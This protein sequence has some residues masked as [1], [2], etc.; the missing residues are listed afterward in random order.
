VDGGVKLG[1]IG[2]DGRELA[3]DV[4]RAWRRVRPRRRAIDGKP[5][6]GT[7]ITHGRRRASR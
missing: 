4:L 5:H 7:A 3:L 2:D 6:T 1:L